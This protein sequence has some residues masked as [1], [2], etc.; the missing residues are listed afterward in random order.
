[1]SCRSGSAAGVRSCRE[2]DCPLW[3]FRFGKNP[4]LKREPSDA[5]RREACRRLETARQIKESRRKEQG[6]QWKS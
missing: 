4:M 3:A 6:N 1:M 5:E 2:E